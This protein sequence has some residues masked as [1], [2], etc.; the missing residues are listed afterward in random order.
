MDNAF[1]LSGQRVKS[2][3]FQQFPGRREKR[4]SEKV[5]LL[6]GGLPAIALHIRYDRI[7][8]L[9]SQL[10]EKKSVL[11]GQ[12]FGNTPVHPVPEHTD[13]LQRHVRVLQHEVF[14][15]Q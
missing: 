14:Q 15:G 13:F 6:G 1:Y 5:P 12:P 9:Q 7:E 10:L 11:M 8:N 3:A 2:A 4:T